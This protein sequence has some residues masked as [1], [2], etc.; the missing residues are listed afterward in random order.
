MYE[1]AK[2]GGCLCIDTNNMV[3]LS[4][5]IESLALNHNLYHNKVDEILRRA[6]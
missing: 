6:Y 3:A 2:D 1:V 4:E 5:A